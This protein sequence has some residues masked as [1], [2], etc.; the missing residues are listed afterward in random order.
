MIHGSMKHG[1]YEYDLEYEEADSFDDL[2]KEQ[3]VQVYGVCFCGD[4]LVIGFGGQKHDWGLIGGTIEPGESYEQTLNRE[5]AEESNMKVLGAK[6]VGYQK[7]IGP[8][9]KVDYQLRYA[10]KVEPIGPFVAD[11]A[12]GVTEIKLI[13][14]AEYRQYFDW[15]QVGEAIITRALNLKNQL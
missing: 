3:V 12:G 14:P 13:N 2:P 7:V 8:S 15:G 10:C 4:K 5:I 9:G 1:D 11:P 6:P